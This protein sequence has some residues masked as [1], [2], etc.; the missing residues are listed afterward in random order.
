MPQIFVLEDAFHADQIGKFTS[1][2]DAWAKVRELS[3]DPTSVENRPP[4]ASWKTCRREYF[5]LTYD[6]SD[7]PWKL[8]ARQAA[9]TIE[10]GVVTSV[11]DQV[12]SAP[13]NPAHESSR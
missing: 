8:V 3:D 13:P 6:Q 7:E 5:V 9:L 11:A 10:A 12:N 2:S 4:C 1:E